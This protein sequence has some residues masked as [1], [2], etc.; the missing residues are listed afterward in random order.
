MR[1]RLAVTGA[2]LAALA[3]EWL[4]HGLA[5]YRVAGVAGLRAGLSGGVHGYMLPIGLVILLGAAAS[6]TVWARAWIVLGRRLDR[7]AAVLARLRAGKR[8]GEVP[9][10]VA[11]TGRRGATSFAARVGALALPIALLQ[12]VLYLV[13]ENLERVL[14][15]LAAPG[16][17]PIVDGFGAAAWIQAAVALVLATA[18]AVATYLLRTRAVAARSCER[19]ARRL[20]ERARR[21]ATS[22]QPRLPHVKAARLLL[23]SAIWQ[24]PPPAPCSA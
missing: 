23:R 3:G 19:L 1:R 24:R 10:A 16:L 14:H 13:Q 5:Y 22:P 17:S 6:A 15:G 2:V 12:C 18:I 21:S 8:V 9:A 7:S 11:A 20:W 4:G